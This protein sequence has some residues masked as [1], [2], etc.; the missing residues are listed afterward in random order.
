MMITLS[1][2]TQ[3]AFTFFIPIPQ[4]IITT[5][6][7]K[8][9]ESLS[10]HLHHQILSYYLKHL[11]LPSFICSLCFSSWS[12]SFCLSVKLSMQINVLSLQTS[13]LSCFPQSYHPTFFI[14]FKSFNV[15]LTAAVRSS[16]IPSTIL[17]CCHMSFVTRF[18]YHYSL[19]K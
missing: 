7:H 3:L 18:K 12:S 19:Y 15:Q 10:P 6:S 13:F 17:L 9:F 11:I 5:F 16:L 8:K 2:S 4:R 1:Q 14:I